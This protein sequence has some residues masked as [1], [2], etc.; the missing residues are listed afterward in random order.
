MWKK[1]IM[2]GLLGMVLA[3]CQGADKTGIE[4]ITKPTAK[5]YINGKEAGN[6]PYKN[7][8]LRPGQTEIRLVPEDSEMLPWQQKVSLESYTY[9]VIDLQFSKED[10]AGGYLLKL[11]PNGDKSKAGLI[12]GTFP[13]KASLTLDGEL[14]GFSP[15]NMPSIPSG[16]HHVVVAMAGY[17]PIEAFVKAMPGYRLFLQGQ[18]T[19]DY[20]VVSRPTE[21][22]ENLTNEVG[23]EMIK[24]KKTETG[25]LRV[26]QEASASSKE[27]AK[28]N[29]GETYEKIGESNDWIQIKL[30][31]GSTGWILSRYA[32]LTK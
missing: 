1:V 29:P 32:E 9:T 30:K 18:M 13:D 31:T 6:T 20:S 23:P 22:L 11:E 2:V 8:S 25:F 15:V 5:V 7:D 21:A 26:R 4:I 12:I 19:H 16:D 10:V 17:K 24:I 28:I 27:L 14:I 3:G